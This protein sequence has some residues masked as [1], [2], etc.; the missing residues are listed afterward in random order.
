MDMSSAAADRRLRLYL[1]SG[2]GHG[3]F[4]D[5]IDKTLWDINKV[6]LAYFEFLHEDNPF[7]VVEDTRCEIAGDSIVC[8]V[9]NIMPNKVLIPRFSYEGKSLTIDGNGHEIDAQ[10]KSGIFR[11]QSF[12]TLK[13]IIFKTLVFFFIM[14]QLYRV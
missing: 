10:G 5:E 4:G 11:V 2:A 1:I 9:S 7:Q 12:V 14:F 6:S 8:W 3:Y 13:N